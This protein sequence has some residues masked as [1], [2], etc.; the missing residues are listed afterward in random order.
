MSQN[1]IKPPE[2]EPFVEET[3]EFWREMGKESIRESI[4]TIDQVAKEII[5]IAGIMQ[6]LYVNVIAIGDLKSASYPILARLVFLLPIVFFIL[7]ITAGLLVFFPE[8]FRLNVNASGSI[9]ASFEHIQA[10]KFHRL[11]W[12][13]FWII[14]G[15]LALLTAVAVYLL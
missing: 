10:R 6:G 12:A 7:S 1:I 13:S 15:F 11:K 5:A 4:K 14:T 2:P 9:K 8:P 3:R